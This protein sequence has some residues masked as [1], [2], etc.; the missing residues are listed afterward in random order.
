MM[1]FQSAEKKKKEIQGEILK[2]I[3]LKPIYLVWY[4][5]FFS[6][7]FLNRLNILDAMCRLAF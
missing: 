6:N 4:F 1:S 3:D 7:D 2:K 5:F